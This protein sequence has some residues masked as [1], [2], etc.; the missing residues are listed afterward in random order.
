MKHKVLSSSSWDVLW[1]QKV[2]VKH[3]SHQHCL[4]WYKKEA[5]EHRYKINYSNWVQKNCSHRMFLISDL[6]CIGKS[7]NWVTRGPLQCKNIWSW[8]ILRKSISQPHNLNR[9]WTLE[10]FSGSS[11]AFHLYEILPIYITCQSNKR[12]SVWQSGTLSS[13]SPIGW[14]VHRKT[15]A[16]YLETKL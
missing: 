3:G 7:F 10:T 13:R 9:G 1:P 14:L 5:T 8:N 15:R 16:A 11:S 2:N 12:A 6:S 4:Q